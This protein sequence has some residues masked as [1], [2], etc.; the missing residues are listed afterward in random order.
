MS[1][2][3]KPLVEF[4]FASNNLKLGF[5][6]GSRWESN[7][8]Y[9]LAL[10]KGRSG[11][12][13]LAS[14]YSLSWSTAVNPTVLHYRDYFLSKALLECLVNCQYKDEAKTTLTTHASK[15][16][17]VYSYDDIWPYRKP[18]AEH[19]PNYKYADVLG[20]LAY[21]LTQLDQDLNPTQLLRMLVNLVWEDL[22]F[23]GSPT[24][25]LTQLYLV[26]NLSTFLN[27]IPET[28][29]SVLEATQGQALEQIYKMRRQQ[30]LLETD[31]LAL[32]VFLG[33]YEDFLFEVTT[34]LLTDF[35]R[36]S[37]LKT[38]KACLSLTKPAGGLL[39]LQALVIEGYLLN[40]ELLNSQPESVL[41][42]SL[43]TF[44]ADSTYSDLKYQLASNLALSYDAYSMQST[45]GS[46][47]AASEKARGVKQLALYW[48]SGSDRS[49][50]LSTDLTRI[51]VSQWYEAPELN[52][53]EAAETSDPQFLALQQHPPMGKTR[54]LKADKQFGNRINLQVT[55][56][57]GNPV[58]G[59]VFPLYGPGSKGNLESTGAPGSY[60]LVLSSTNPVALVAT[61]ISGTPIELESYL[62]LQ[63]A[64]LSLD[65]NFSS[66][67]FYSN[68]VPVFPQPADTTT[69][70][71][72]SGFDDL[73]GTYD[74]L[75]G[76][77]NTSNPRGS[78]G[79]VYLT[80][81]LSEPGQQD[82]QTDLSAMRADIYG[83][84][85]ET[86]ARTLGLVSL[87]DSV[88]LQGA[89]QVFKDWIPS[90]PAEEASTTAATAT[91]NAEDTSSMSGGSLTPES[92]N[93][94]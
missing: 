74:L 78:D 36:E 80:N 58:E 44:Y 42:T 71:I 32:R 81:G 2:R 73:L 89:I 76:L 69:A 30:L 41:G 3:S 60:S 53:A 7:R 66:D 65:S 91:E 31:K 1:L 23:K 72:E 57:L 84:R 67:L 63:V 85:K 61:N 6:V 12:F 16:W 52:V 94:A 19:P 11:L 47:Y 29:A 14:E 20:S 37:I 82:Y 39:V 45:W 90:D 38:L 49:L 33:E 5:E 13:Q 93:I 46:L 24:E 21:Y 22:G 64:S 9:L 15:A 87:L 27:V 4:P 68:V 34:P 25:R 79:D 18:V 10:L 75:F 83:Y 55:D 92:T 35:A 8:Q 54:L 43:D 40:I 59:Q 48:L 56:I 88:H 17:Q 86:T 51:N 28:L 77:Q 70:D 26:L 50:V 62:S